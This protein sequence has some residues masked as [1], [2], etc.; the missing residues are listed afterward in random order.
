L[1]ELRAWYEIRKQQ[2]AQLDD[3]V[4]GNAREN[5]ETVPP[6]IFTQI[7][8]IITTVTGISDAHFHQFRHAFASWL[9]LSLMLSDLDPAPN[10]FPHLP[11]T[12]AWLAHGYA[13]SKQL[14]LNAQHTR[15]HAYL[16]AQ[17][18]G[19]GS[20]DTSMENYVH[21]LDWLLA[22]Y[23]RR[24]PRMNPQDENVRDASGISRS[25]LQRWEQNRGVVNI[26]IQLARREL[27]ITHR[28]LQQVSE[29]NPNLEE[30]RVENSSIQTQ[31]DA[32]WQY[33]YEVQTSGRPEEEIQKRHN[34]EK[35]EADGMMA[36]AQYLC[37]LTFARGGQRHRMETWL[38]DARNSLN[39]RVLSCPRKPVH[40]SKKIN[41]TLLNSVM[42]YATLNSQLFARAINI[43]V[44]RVQDDAFVRFD[45]LQDESAAK[46]YY[47][48]L[49]AIGILKQNILLVSGDR[50]E[51]SHYRTQWHE[52]LLSSRS[53][54]TKP[55]SK[56]YFGPKSALSMRP[57]F[58]YSTG[59]TDGDS[60]L[61][62]MLVMLFILFG[63]MS[64]Q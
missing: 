61:R 11:K 41:S 60:G 36:R 17:L 51:R 21:L 5:M 44:H 38:P 9:F 19:H 3:C 64:A 52:L 46:T 20:P 26:P 57:S 13:L 43:Y 56:A 29:P 8:K 24:S 18:L 59:D 39:E 32:A 22:I 7:N 53:P 28:V 1:L 58:R 55:S 33:L 54:I 31:I 2:G 62:F 4:F 45:N 40:E 14:Y 50:A 16:V 23:L 63:K 12:T 15:R 27:R 6:S 47:D 48:F 42:E 30:K 34:L 49:T 35:E 25:T 37:G 10:L